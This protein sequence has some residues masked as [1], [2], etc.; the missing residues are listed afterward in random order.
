MLD[1]VAVVIP[2]FNEKD[3]IEGVVDAV[4]NTLPK[5]RIIIVDDGSSDGTRAVVNKLAQDNSNIHIICRDGR[6][7]LGLAYK[8]GFRYVLNNLDAAYIFQM[9]SDF[10]HNPKYLPLFLDYAAKYDLVVGSRFLEKNSIQNRARW[11][12]LVS[13]LATRSASVL[14]GLG[15]SDLTTGFKCFKRGVLEG[16]DF[17]KISSV[18]YAFQIEMSYYVIKQGG[19]VKELPI[20]FSERKFGRSK[21]SS[22]VILEGVSIIFKLAFRR[23]NYG[24]AH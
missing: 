20:I 6:R 11:R 3:N 7:G 13:I 2:T 5:A 8:D 15:L 21:I 1:K 16:I 14:L 17:T 10:S 18:G 19:K 23:M 9:D 22:K 4:V 12:N 24:G